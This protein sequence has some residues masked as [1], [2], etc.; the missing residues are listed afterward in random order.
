MGNI[1]VGGIVIL[2]LGSAAY[3][4]YKKSKSGGS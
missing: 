3:S 2:V 1:I 4:L